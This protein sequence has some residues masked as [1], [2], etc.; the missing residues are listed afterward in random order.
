MYAVFFYIDLLY[1]FF[2]LLDIK[3]IINFGESS[4]GP[5][6]SGNMMLYNE[7]SQPGPSSVQDSSLLHDNSHAQG[8]FPFSNRNPKQA[9]KI[10]FLTFI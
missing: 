3:P 9:R 5:S 2:F 8:I 7:Q 6:E 4:A 10:K 1:S